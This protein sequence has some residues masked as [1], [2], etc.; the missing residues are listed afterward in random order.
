MAHLLGIDIGTSGTKT[1]IC[2]EDGNVVATANAEH[3]IASPK[4]GWSEQDPLQWWDATCKATKA[5]LKKAKLKKDDISAI[6]LSGQMHGSVFLDDS[7]SGKPLRPALLWN[8]QRTV[9]Q[10]ADIE[11]KAGSRKK[12]INMVGNPALTGFTAPKIL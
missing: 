9:K 10:C 8:D 1:L 7:G 6:G 5:A 11:A 4:P 3:D 2:N 12:L